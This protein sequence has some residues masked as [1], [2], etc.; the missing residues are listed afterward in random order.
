MRAA[1]ACLSIAVV[2]GL[3]ACTDAEEDSP[4]TPLPESTILT[5]EAETTVP[6]PAPTT[7][8]TTRAADPPWIGDVYVAAIEAACDAICPE[9]GAWIAVDPDH[10][11]Y[12]EAIAAIGLAYADVRLVD[13]NVAGGYPWT[14]DVL[15]IARV[16]DRTNPAVV[17]LQLVFDADDADRRSPLPCTDVF[18]AATEAGTWAPANPA[19]FAVQD[20]VAYRYQGRG[21]SRHWAE[22]DM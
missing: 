14:G 7:T 13:P 22:S 16:D 18:L 5:T 20:P 11:D 3:S 10:S 8:T 9:T 6:E 12:D 17:T 4:T 15:R 19:D 2:V 21:C 1:V